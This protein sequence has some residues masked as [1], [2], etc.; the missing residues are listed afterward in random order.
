[1]SSIF[2]NEHNHAIDVHEFLDA[3]WSV[4]DFLE[5]RELCS[6]IRAAIIT[7]E[8]DDADVGSMLGSAVSDLT[9]LV[10]S[11]GT[12]IQPLGQQFVDA[13]AAQIRYL[14]NSDYT[15]A[16]VLP[17][18]Y[19]SEEDF[20]ALIESEIYKVLHPDL[21]T[22]ASALPF[23]D[24]KEKALSEQKA[25]LDERRDIFDHMDLGLPDEADEPH[26]SAWAK[27][28]A[29]DIEQ[30]EK[31]DSLLDL[32][33]HRIDEL[34]GDSVF[35]AQDSCLYVYKGFIKCLRDHHDII[36]VNAQIPNAYG[37][38]ASLNVNYCSDCKRFFISYEEYSHYLKQYG[39]LLIKIILLQNDLYSDYDNDLAA[40]SPL[41]LCGYSVS[42]EAGLT[43]VARQNLLTTV[44]HNGIMKKFEVIRYLNWFITM[45]G[46]KFGNEIAK[47]KWEE[48]LRFVRELDCDT[49]SDHVINN[50]SIYGK[51][52]RFSKEDG[53]D[54]N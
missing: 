16:G 1:M 33:Q 5:Y 29:A 24:T 26:L 35:D 30:I 27:K 50:L 3:D 10:N 43:T 52:G 34:S 21:A 37:K 54:G 4:S 15:G 28:K 48:D 49:Q 46:S 23:C 51:F 32:L 39:T 9:E 2:S 44:I 20:R 8:S 40:A 53:I 12:S 38:T 7:A 25:Y 22:S 11:L 42:M 36:C 19:R 13:L 41:K 17:T 45:Q 18:F 47:M 6:K 31:I 14:D